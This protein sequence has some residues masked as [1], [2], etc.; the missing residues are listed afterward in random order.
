M[1]GN[2][3]YDP[4]TN[5]DDG[6]LVH[7]IIE[8]AHSAT[9]CAVI[10]GFRYRGTLVPDMA[11]MYVYGDLCSAKSWCDALRRNVVVRRPE[12]HDLRDLRL[13]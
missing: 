12:R 11:G 1:E 7:P 5:C 6:T 8:Y 2:H 3:C 13:R 4:A 10:G 9:R